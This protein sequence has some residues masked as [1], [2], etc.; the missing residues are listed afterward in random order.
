MAD[1]GKTIVKQGLDKY[2]PISRMKYYF[3]VDT[4]YVISKLGLLFFPFMHSVSNKLLNVLFLSID[5]LKDWSIKYEQEGNPV[6]PRYEINAPDL[7]IPT[8]A[9]F[10]FILVSGLVLGK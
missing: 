4:K 5:I 1:T 10:T 6:Q 9:Y 8:M 7:Y 2:V 3:A